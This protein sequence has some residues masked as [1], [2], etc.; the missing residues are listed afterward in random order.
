MVARLALAAQLTMTAKLVRVIGE[1]NEGCGGEGEGE[2]GEVGEGGEG[3]ECGEDGEATGEGGDCNE[4]DP[5]LRKN[6][7]PSSCGIILTCLATVAG[8][9]LWC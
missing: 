1:G 8:L 7:S 2:G 5:K 6:R 3:G 4:D 9:L